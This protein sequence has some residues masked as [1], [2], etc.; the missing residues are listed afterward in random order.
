[1]IKIF[2]IIIGLNVGGAELMLKRLVESHHGNADYRHS[3]ISLTAIGKVGEE[4][5][6]L[7]IEV[8]A[9]GMRTVLDIPL[10][11]W[12]LICLIRTSCPAVVQ[13]WMYH[14]DL[15]GG[16]AA[17]S[18]GIK[19][20]IW[21]V[22]GTAIPQSGF[23]ITKCIIKACAHLSSFLPK[24]IICCAESARVAHAKMGYCRDRM[25]VIPNGYDLSQFNFDSVE[26]QQ[27]RRNFGFGLDEVVIGIVGRFD[28]LKD[29]QNFVL[30]AA[31][32]ARDNPNVKFLMI[33]R[34]VD[35]T[36]TILRSWIVENG[37]SNKMTLA[38][39]RSDISHCLAAMDIFCLS[40]KYEGFP[41]VVCEAMAMK[42]PCVVTN[43]GDA[44]DIVA[45]TGIVVPTCDSDALALGLKKMIEK[46]HEQ[47]SLLGQLARFRI[48]EHYSIEASA[49]QFS[50]IYDELNNSSITH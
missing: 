2:H 46:G 26:S 34:D 40:S 44:A 25:V 20:I 19:N 23:S 45:E 3:V 48:E 36:N 13:T 33:G 27:L 18:T 22:R 37:L 14:A 7:G 41:N 24:V 8:H 49:S 42:I 17:R 15:L 1:M 47:R 29:H 38:G 30:A 21:G 5:Q 35:S 12:M 11:F 10:A 4:L 50:A 39:Q 43:A 32:V 16:L 9:L 31:N 28:P 6:A